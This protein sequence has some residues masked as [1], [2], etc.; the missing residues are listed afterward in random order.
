MLIELGT[1]QGARSKGKLVKSSIYGDYQ[2][3]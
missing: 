3:F 1:V 2:K